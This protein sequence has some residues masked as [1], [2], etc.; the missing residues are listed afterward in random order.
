MNSIQ[1]KTKLQIS[2]ARKIRGS[3]NKGKYEAALPNI[4]WTT[5][6][7]Y[8]TPVNSGWIVVTR[9]RGRPKWTWINTKK[10]MQAADLSK[11]MVFSRAQQRKR[12]IRQP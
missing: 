3:I 4:A 10:K 8:G 9:T 6:K 1:E 7:T 2:V 12:F 11:E 5:T